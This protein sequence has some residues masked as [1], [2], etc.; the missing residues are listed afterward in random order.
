MGIASVRAGMRSLF[1][2]SMFSALRR[3][4]MWREARAEDRFVKSI[5]SSCGVLAFDYF[6]I[7]ERLKEKGNKVFYVLGSGSSVEDLTHL[8]F[9]I[10]SQEV[11]AGINA[12]VLHDFVPDIYSFEPATRRESDHYSKMQFLN[13]EEVFMRRPSIMFLKPR[14][15]IELEQLRMVP[16]GLTGE[17]MVYGRFQPYTRKSSNLVRDLSLIKESRFRELSV[18]P[19][20]GASIIRMAFL[21]IMLGFTKIVFVGV[22]LNHTEYFWERNPKYLDRVGLASF[23]SGQ[24]GK[25]HETLSSANRAFGVVEMIKAIRDYGELEGVSLEVSNPKSLLSEILPVHNFREV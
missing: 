21:A 18:V 14:T 9:E 5:V 17:V 1:E 22:D 2:L 25:E 12:W 11:S 24:V 8:D 13:R 3:Q 10:I 16:S 19:D 20:S 15:A 23:S 7:E 4:L 6:Q